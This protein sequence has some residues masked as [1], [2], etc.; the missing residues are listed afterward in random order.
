VAG[1]YPTAE[2][3][4]TWNDNK[5]DPTL[6]PPGW[7]TRKQM[8]LDRV[9]ERR[10]VHIVT[11]YFEH[12]GWTVTTDQQASGVGYDLLLAGVRVTTDEPSTRWCTGRRS[13]RVSLASASK[14]RGGCFCRTSA[15]GTP[16]WPCR[17]PIGSAHPMRR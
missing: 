7:R 3:V 16:Y 12:K 8:Q 11:R 10:A 1:R 6:K 15:T 13:N 14:M 5:S 4:S 9:T 2:I 17:P